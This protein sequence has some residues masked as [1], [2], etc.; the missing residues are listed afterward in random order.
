MPIVNRL[1]VTEPDV[2][3]PDAVQAEVSQSVVTQPVA[4]Q[5][6][7]LA[8]A[9]DRVY[10][11]LTASQMAAAPGTSNASSAGPGDAWGVPP[12]DNAASGEPW[13][14]L[15][16]LRTAFGLSAFERDVL[17]LCAGH[18][19]E[20]RFAAACASAL[21]D[22]RA[23]WPT[24]ALALAVLEDPHW[25]AVSSAGPL[26]FWRL[27]SMDP[28]S[29]LHAPLSIDERILAYLLRIPAIDER[30]QPLVRPIRAEPSADSAVASRDNAIRAGAAHWLRS[31]EP[32]E[33]VLLIGSSGAASQATFTAICERTGLRPFAL[34]ARDIPDAATDREQLGRLWTREAALS[35]AAL[36]VRSADSEDVHALSAWLQV[37]SAPVAVEVRPGTSAER[38]DGVRLHLPSMSAR[39]R[40]DLWA[41][42]LGPVAERMDGYLDRIVEYFHFDESAIRV[43]ATAMRATASAGDNTDPGPAGWRICREHARRSLDTLASRVEPQAGWADLVL[44]A[45]QVQTLRQVAIHVRQRAVVNDAWGFASKHA[46][47]LGLSALFSGPTGTGKTM[48]AGIVAAELDLDLYKID[49]AAVVSKYI[50]ETE[51]N[52]R[53][54]FSA[55]QESGAVLLFDEA[56]ALFGKRSE[57]R[58]SHDR[59]ANLEISYLLQQMEAYRGVA[60][61]TTNMQQALDPAFLRRIRFIVPFPFPDASARAMIWRRI[62]PA[63]TPLGDLDF[64]QLAQLNISGGVIRNIAMHAAFLAADDSSA[65]GRRAVAARHILAAARTEYAKMEKQLTAAETRG[66]A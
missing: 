14:A 58:D 6:E 21:G 66:L 29:Q 5:P 60:I 37:T 41:R 43:T 30:L 31:Q 35:S 59:Y 45:L 27:V 16:E 54:I 49:L 42:D 25:T 36:F 50:G 12:G 34:D 33:P 17:V 23:T 46:R 7:S 39:E 57:V 10:A 52:L 26:R 3:R 51:K 56:D 63:S 11:R 13:Y 61:L 62:F 19:L 4:T 38:L 1:N 24:L 55:A 8:S 15:E 47:G 22:A 64:D 32:G 2:A 28:G 20:S 40:K 48:A 44:P 18:S 9:L 53:A 65:G